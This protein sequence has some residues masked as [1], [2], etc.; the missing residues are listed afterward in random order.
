MTRNRKRKQD[1]RKF[2]EL[3][4]VSYLQARRQNEN[5][6][7]VRISTGLPTV[8]LYTQGLTPGQVTTIASRPGVG[9]TI[10]AS[11][12]L[13]K[14]LKGNRN[15]LVFS[16]EMSRKEFLHRLGSAAG[17]HSMN[18]ENFA[19]LH[20]ENFAGGKVTVDDSPQTP[21]TIREL[22]LKA[23][24]EER[25]DLIVID[26][27]ELLERNPNER[28]N[29]ALDRFSRAVRALALELNV[30]IVVVSSLNRRH[31]EGEAQL[32]ELKGSLSLAAAS[33]VVILLDRI[34]ELDN[35]VNVILSKN[36]NGVSA[37]EVSCMLIPEQQLIVE[38]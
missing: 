37:L 26:S 36:R 6:S 14:A 4:D 3:N 23:S 10:L 5:S 22:A 19:N 7:L 13:M 15:A 20:G 32:S 8:D 30:P 33:D 24:K 29:E 16:L 28:F 9:K 1:L 21:E 35:G 38:A 25:L 11:T 12:L 18:D 31:K 17:I 27:F 2:M 34:T